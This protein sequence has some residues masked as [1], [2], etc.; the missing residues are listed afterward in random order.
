[1]MAIDDNK[2]SFLRLRSKYL[3]EDGPTEV[4]AEIIL[5]GI[6]LTRL[7]SLHGMDFIF[8]CHAY[9]LCSWIMHYLEDFCL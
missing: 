9:C 1:M 8:L 5:E 6:L 3:N 4:V 7:E 2:I